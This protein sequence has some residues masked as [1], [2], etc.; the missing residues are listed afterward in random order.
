MSK[1]LEDLNTLLKTNSEQINNETNNN[2]NKNEEEN[3]NE[4]DKEKENDDLK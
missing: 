1:K 3:L 2:N 4:K